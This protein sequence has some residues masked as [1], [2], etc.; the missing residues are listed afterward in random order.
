MERWKLN[1]YMLWM[2]Q[3]VSLMSLNFGVP[4]LS[5]YIQDLGVVNP[6]SIKIYVSLLSM[7]PSVATAV[8]A[9]LWGMAADRYGRKLMLLRAM[10]FASIMLAGMGMVTNVNQLVVLR[11]VQGLT[12]GTMAAATAFVAA[13]TPAEHLSYAL[14]V[15]T[16][17]N[18]IGLS[19]GPVIGGFLA[20]FTSYR[21]SFYIGGILMFIDFIIVMLLVK[22]DATVKPAAVKIKTKQSGLA[23]IMNPFILSI[24]IL[25][26]LLRISRTVFSPYLSLYVQEMLGGAKGSVVITGLINGAVALMTAISCFMAGRLGDRVNKAA[27]LRILLIT[28]LFVSVVILFTNSLWT[29]AIAYSLFFLIFGGM[30][31]IAVSISTENTPVEKR[32]ML[33]GIQSTVGAIGAMLAP[34]MAGMVA[35]EFSVQAILYLMPITLIPGLIMIFVMK[36]RPSAAGEGS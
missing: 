14:G 25:L 11:V 33:F 10:L 27:L 20:E 3:I 18:F 16:S 12:T 31:P 30:E 8:S 1:L 32:G 36:M 28:G 35:L 34:V 5:F 2:S 13:G 29:F 17:A 26:I 21:T 22:E 6:D 19:L 9:P 23:F 4:F 15:I 24:L 7:G